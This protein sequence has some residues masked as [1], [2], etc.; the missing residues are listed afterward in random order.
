MIRSTRDATAAREALILREAAAA[1][2]AAGSD[3]D[4]PAA[5]TSSTPTG[6]AD[7]EGHLPLAAGYLDSANVLTHSPLA[8]GALGST[9]PG[10]S[11]TAGAASAGS[12]GLM[13]G[14]AGSAVI[15]AAPGGPVQLTAAAASMV[16]DIERLIRNTQSSGG[17]QVWVGSSWS[18]STAS[19]HQASHSLGKGLSLCCPW[20]R[21]QHAILSFLQRA[22]TAL[23]EYRCDSCSIESQHA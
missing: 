1:S 15:S 10:Y 16:G 8:Q 3:S 12:G 18:C 23:L 20:I 11:T 6:T 19:R 4:S 5:P 22:R 7:P 13:S 2:T 21:L 17:A 14:F 9:G